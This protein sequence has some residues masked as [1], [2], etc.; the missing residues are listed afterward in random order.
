MRML[1]R[2]LILSRPIYLNYLRI[3]SGLATRNMFL[4]QRIGEASLWIRLHVR[5]I[6]GV[7]GGS[8]AGLQYGITC[9]LRT[10]TNSYIR[11]R[12]TSGK[13]KKLTFN[14]QG[15]IIFTCDQYIL[16]EFTTRLRKLILQ[17]SRKG[18]IILSYYYRGY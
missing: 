3:R 15:G 9:G 10:R 18:N 2:Y 12:A 7:I 1:F 4:E 6:D 5:S 14:F 11:R 13:E 16:L 17:Y 8:A